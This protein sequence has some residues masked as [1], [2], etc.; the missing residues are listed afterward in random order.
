MSLEKLLELSSNFELTDE[1]TPVQAW[2]LIRSH[3]SFEAM[4]ITRLKTL[5]Q[6]LLNHIECHGYISRRTL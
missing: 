1:L 2:H 5:T 4:E 3:P 6:E